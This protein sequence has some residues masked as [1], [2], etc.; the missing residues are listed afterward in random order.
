MSPFDRVLIVM[1]DNPDPDAIATG[2]AIHRLVGERCGLPVRLV[3]GGEIVR[4]ENRHMVELLN[5][6]I[7]NENCALAPI[8]LSDPPKSDALRELEPM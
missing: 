2:W 7:E 4:A 3:A 8:R 6:P 1:H 5:P